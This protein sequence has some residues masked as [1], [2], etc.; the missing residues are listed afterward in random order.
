LPNQ[1]T[2]TR[3]SASSGNPNLP[4]ADDE[5]LTAMSTPTPETNNPDTSAEYL[6]DVYRALGTVDCEKVIKQRG[7][8]TIFH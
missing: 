2:L 4:M 1:V 3:I 5:A 6:V 8:G 7:W